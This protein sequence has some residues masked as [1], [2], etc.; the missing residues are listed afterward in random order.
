MRCT[1]CG[2]GEVQQKL[3]RYSLS[4]E[5]K[6]VVVDHVPANVCGNCGETSFSPEVVEKLQNTVWH[7]HS[8]VRTLETPVYEFA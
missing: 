5:D 3:V 8:P 4:F 2:A 6:L 1:V 7:T